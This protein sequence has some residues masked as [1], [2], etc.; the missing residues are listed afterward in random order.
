M[1]IIGIGID[2]ESLLVQ[3]QLLVLNGSKYG[4]GLDWTTISRLVLVLVLK[5]F[6]FD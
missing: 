5:W 2:L 1:L 4:I 3:D 6:G